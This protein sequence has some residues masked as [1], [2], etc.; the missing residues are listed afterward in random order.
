[1]AVR[2]NLARQEQDLAAGGRDRRRMRTKSGDMV[3]VSL[4]IRGTATPRVYLRFKFGGGTIERKVATVIAPSRSE[5]LKI[6][7]NIIRREKIIEKEGWSWIVTDP[8]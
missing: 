6:G 3:F 1:M 7:W 5:T 4:A 8:E 2:M